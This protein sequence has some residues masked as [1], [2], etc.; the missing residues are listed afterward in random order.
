MSTLSFTNRSMILTTGVLRDV[1]LLKP[2]ADENKDINQQA[3]TRLAMQMNSKRL[4]LRT[5]P[6]IAT[7]DLD[8]TMANGDQA[9][10][11]VSMDL[12]VG[13]QVEANHNS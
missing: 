3:E 7:V 5:M 1:D 11:F 12:L 8:W 9:K 10:A 6:S 2:N 4:H 13:E